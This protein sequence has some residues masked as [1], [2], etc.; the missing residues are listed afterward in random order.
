[1]PS[2]RG[3][4]PPLW[5]GSEETVLQAVRDHQQGGQ[6]WKQQNGYE[7]H[8]VPL[9]RVMGCVGYSVGGDS[10]VPGR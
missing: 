8:D 1:M 10:W 6:Q 2:P 7:D 5:H 3:M 4:P 9:D